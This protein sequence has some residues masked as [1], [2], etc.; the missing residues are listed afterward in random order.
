MSNKNDLHNYLVKVNDGSGVFFKPSDVSSSRYLITANHVVKQGHHLVITKGQRHFNI[1]NPDAYCIYQS[2]ND[3]ADIAV[4]KFDDEALADVDL[5]DIPHTLDIFHGEFKKSLIAGFPNVKSGTID[6]THIFDFGPLTLCNPLDNSDT[7]Y[8]FKIES[9]QVIQTN[10]YSDIDGLKG[11]SGGGVYVLGADKKF[12]LAGIV[13]DAAHYSNVIFTSIGILQ[14]QINNQAK[15]GKLLSYENQFFDSYELNPDKDKLSE[16]KNK[17]SNSGMGLFTNFSEASDEQ[18]FVKKSVG[19]VRGTANTLREKQREISTFYLYVGLYYHE[20][21]MHANATKYLKNAIDFDASNT[22]ILE[23]ALYDRKTKKAAEIISKNNEELIESIKTSSGN[24]NKEELIE[25]SK[26]SV[27]HEAKRSLEEA[28][29]KSSLADD[30]SKQKKLLSVCSI[31]LSDNDESSQT[32]AHYLQYLAYKSMQRR[33][34]ENKSAK[35][36]VR[37]FLRHRQAEYCFYAMNCCLHLVHNGN[38]GISSFS[39]VAQHW[40]YDETQ[41]KIYYQLYGEVIETD[42]NNQYVENTLLKAQQIES[43]YAD[44]FT[45]ISKHK[46]F[47][48]SNNLPPDQ[49][50]EI[51]LDFR[52]S[53]GDWVNK[54]QTKY[55]ICDRP[56]LVQLLND[57]DKEIAQL[58]AQ[59]KSQKKPEPSNEVKEHILESLFASIRKLFSTRKVS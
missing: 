50:A 51:L 7:E 33:A 16:L 32:E 8:R 42:L 53:C 59:Q 52:N 38:E 44:A 6:E 35:E 55:S 43:A 36:T 12:H 34:E 20:K 25:L 5:P 22:K 45:Q 27:M 40:N 56:N 49:L 26:Q 18:S 13:T 4:F 19:T 2:P 37:S 23:K 54:I 21:G 14:G 47:V 3:E 57:R 24:N 28:D 41:I 9:E 48:Q 17:I 46:D 31:H 10:Y 30:Y 39:E 29:Y 1:H 11:C 58:K 15:T